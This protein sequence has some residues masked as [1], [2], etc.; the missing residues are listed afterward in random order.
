MATAK[1]ANLATVPPTDMSEEDATVAL[2]G[3]MTV[4]NVTTGAPMGFTVVSVPDA[5][6][7]VFKDAADRQKPIYLGLASTEKDRV[8]M[9]NV[10]R[11]AA[12]QLGKSARIFPGV[13]S[14]GDTFARTFKIGEDGKQNPTYE[15]ASHLKVT[16]GGKSSGRPRKDAH[17]TK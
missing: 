12:L 13:W 5:I 2:F 17:D 3:N 4:G 7:A 16:L 14:G 1:R 9:N 6:L 15:G 8:H 10:I 11:S